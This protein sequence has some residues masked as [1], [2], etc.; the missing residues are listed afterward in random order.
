MLSEIKIGA[1][2]ER[3]C[4]CQQCRIHRRAILN[5]KRGIGQRQGRVVHSQLSVHG[6]ESDQ[7]LRSNEWNNVFQGGNNCGIKPE[8]IERFVII[9]FRLQACRCANRT[10]HPSAEIVC[11]GVEQRCGVE[12]HYRTIVFSS[13]LKVLCSGNKQIG[14]NIR[15]GNL[16]SVQ[17]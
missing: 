6:T 11:F 4:I 1:G 17:H 15:A 2:K 16:L 14:R 13:V 10:F 12:Q 3:V 7:P 5:V 9:S 8:C